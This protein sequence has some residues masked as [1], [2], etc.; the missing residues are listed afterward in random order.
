[1]ISSLHLVMFNFML[2]LTVQLW[3]PLIKFYWALR[4]SGPSLSVT[5]QSSTNFQR[6]GPLSR[7]SLI[8]TKNKTGPSTVPYGTLPLVAFHS[9]SQL[10]HIV[11]HPVNIGWRYVRVR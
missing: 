5:L 1:M 6:S 8:I 2:L 11:D 10:Q 3:K 9:G 4:S 7:R